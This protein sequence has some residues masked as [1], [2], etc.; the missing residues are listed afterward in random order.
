MNPVLGWALAAAMVALSWLA[1]GWPG[2]VMAASVVVF[3]LLLQFNRA[4]RVMK[5]A[6]NAPVGSVPSAVMFNAKLKPGMTMIQIVSMT[7]SLGRKLSDAPEAWQW[8]DAAGDTVDVSFEHGR[9]SRWNLTRA[10]DVVPAP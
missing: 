6:A 3:W 8:A 9:C 5:N 2:V 10:A 1:Y 4:M 7:K